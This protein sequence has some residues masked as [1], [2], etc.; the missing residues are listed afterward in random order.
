MRKTFLT[1]CVAALSLLA[2]SSCG[3]IEDSLNKLDQGLKDLA[4]RVDKLEKDLNDKIDALSKTVTALDAA[5]KAADA[6]LLAKIEAGDK[7][8]A[9]EI[10]A[11]TTKLDAVDGKVDGYIK[12]N[13]EALA[14]ALKQYQEDLKKLGD[15]MTEAQKQ[16]ADADAAILKALATVGV[17]K[18]EKNEDGNAVLTFTDGTTLVVGAYDPNANNT[19]V[20]TVVEDEDG[21]KY[22]AV[23]LE[24]GTKK[25]LEIPVSHTEIDFKVDEDNYLLYSV[26][27][28]EWVS[29]GAYVADD[30]D[31]LI[32]FYWGETDEIDWDTY[33]YIKEDFY[34][35]VFGG[36]TYY[37]PIYK[38]DN[39]VVT[40]KAGKT[41]FAYGEAKTIDVAVADVTEMYVMTKPDGWKA[42]LNGTKLTVT[43][44]S[45][46][47][48]TAEVAEAEGEVLLH[49]T[50]KE[51]KCKV[52]KLAVS[53]TEGFS[54]TVN[55]DGSFTLVNPYV[56]VQYDEMWDEYY[57]EFEDAVIGL[58]PI[59]SFEKDPAA[60]VNAITSGEAYS[61]DVAFFVNNWKSNTMDWDTMEYTVGGAYEYGV[62][63]V[64]V[65]ESTVADV[66]KFM[67]Y[68][69]LPR[70]SQFIV[71]AVPVDASNGSPLTDELVFGYYTPMDVNMEVI[72]EPSFNE[73][74]VELTLYGAEK[75]YIGHVAKEDCFNWNTETYDLEEYLRMYI[76][77]LQYGVNYIGM[78]FEP[79]VH[80][81]TLSELVS[82][83]EEA[84]PLTPDTEYFGF[85]LPIISGKAAADYSFADVISFDFKTASLTEGGDIVV[86]FENETET[87]TQ[88]SVELVADGASMGYYQWYTTDEFNELEDVVADLL[89]GESYMFAGDYALANKTVNPG[90]SYVLAAIAV[91]EAGQYGEVEYVNLEAP[92]LVYSETFVAT[93]GEPVFVENGSNWKVTVPVTVEGG[94]AAKYY[95]YWNTSVRTEEQLQKLPL[96]SKAYYY[97]FDSTTAPKDLV[98]YSYYSAYQ[99]AVVVEST[100]GELSKPV[101]ITVNKPS[102]E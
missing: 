59:S 76:S 66:Y 71:W 2:V 73:I 63:E 25:S 1:F 90:E 23:V 24:D 72:D 40:I 99:Y 15:S 17:T 39:S 10:T 89:E 88:L 98:F 7:E 29:T 4:A 28:G 83:M 16:F 60:Y 52:A 62:Y 80:E 36:E 65:I 87:Y 13:D 58:A 47:N 31:S 18:V 30:Q 38:V 20:V 74:D 5:Y 11:L 21:V 97:Y 102:A 78:E 81:A 91:D 77:Y 86:A 51:G 70:G 44:P 67:N 94:E 34:T 8:L 48:V 84:A 61:D 64:D 55:A 68:S 3:K 19:G 101:I 35:V 56:N 14:A 100:T 46:A 75:F 43:A 93:A 95:Y 82:E 32:D 12:S 69:E 27:G 53:T 54:L 41:Y 45:E 49:C 37:L 57:G 26:N 79:G 85:V 50:T 42:K 33:E 96:G 6:E 92:E 9:A 22:W